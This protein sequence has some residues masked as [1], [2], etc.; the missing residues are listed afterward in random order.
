MSRKEKPD[1][2]NDDRQL[3]RHP[4]E[5]HPRTRRPSG[6]ATTHLACSLPLVRCGCLASV[7]QALLC[8]A[9]LGFLDYVFAA[10]ILLIMVRCASCL[11]FHD[12]HEALRNLPST[13]PPETPHRRNSYLAQSRV[14]SQCIVRSVQAAAFKD[15]SFK[16]NW[17]R[18]FLSCNVEMCHFVLWWVE[19]SRSGR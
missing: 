7:L 12:E 15:L 18:H 6:S 17:I 10:L 3:R 11:R 2:T 1:R 16:M 5:G 4:R 14:E 13:F 9:V 8:A 19:G